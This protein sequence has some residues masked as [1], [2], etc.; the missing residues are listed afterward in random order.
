MKISVRE[1]YPTYTWHWQLPTPSSDDVC[2]ICRVSFDGTC[3][4]CIY[5]GDGCPLTVGTCVHAFHEHCIAKWL[6]QDG[7]KGLCPMCRQH[8]QRQEEP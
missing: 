5:P 7:S 1:V 8:F 6:D 4:N 3:P 2:G